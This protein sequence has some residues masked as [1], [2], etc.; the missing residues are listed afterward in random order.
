MGK[1]TTL[2]IPVYANGTVIDTYLIPKPID[3]TPYKNQLREFVKGLEKYLANLVKTNEI[4]SNDDKAYY[5]YL[6]IPIKDLEI[7]HKHLEQAYP[8]IIKK[9]LKMYENKVKALIQEIN[10][11]PF[12]RSTSEY[13]AESRTLFKLLNTVQQKHNEM[14]VKINL[15]QE[16]LLLNQYIPFYPLIANLRIFYFNSIFNRYLLFTNIKNPKYIHNVS[17]S[18]I[19]KTLHIACSKEDSYFKLYKAFEE[20]KYLK[21]E[22]SYHINSKNLY[23]LYHFIVYIRTYHHIIKKIEFVF[24]DEGVLVPDKYNCKLVEFYNRQNKRYFHVFFGKY[25]SFSKYLC[26]EYEKNIDWLDK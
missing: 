12:K 16:D 18:F 7:L 10:W 3:L 19:K 17:C 6:N 1:R 22:D 24:S 14:S 23:R 9:E 4:N 21:E 13:I 2:T 15:L 5:F 26:R 11:F 20:L 8:T 25:A